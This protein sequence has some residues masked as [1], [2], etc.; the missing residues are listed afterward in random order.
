MALRK[1]ALQRISLQI[2]HSRKL[3]LPSNPARNV[4]GSWGKKWTRRGVNPRPSACQADV[5][6]RHREPGLWTPARRQATS[7]YIAIAERER[8]ANTPNRLKHRALLKLEPRTRMGKG[9]ARTSQR[10][11][12]K[13]EGKRTALTLL[14]LPLQCASEIP[15]R[16]TSQTL[17]QNPKSYAAHRTTY[18]K[19][20]VAQK[21]KRPTDTQVTQLARSSSNQDSRAPLSRPSAFPCG[22]YRS[23]PFR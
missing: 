12:T 7:I 4:L 5:L 14:A 2:L 13:H 8:N 17:H 20:N 21:S 18:G 11:S 15:I 10:T 23:S 19:H 1:I 3:S 22:K 16:E 6:P 9:R